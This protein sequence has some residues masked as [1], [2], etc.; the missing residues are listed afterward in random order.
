MLA[1]ASAAIAFYR[2]VC[3]RAPIMEDDDLTPCQVY[4]L[5]THKEE[6]RAA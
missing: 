6:R 3:R 2:E 4:E 5:F 1:Y